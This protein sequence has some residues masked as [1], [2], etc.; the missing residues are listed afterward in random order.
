MSP[1]DDLPPGG[2]VRIHR[3]AISLA[4]LA[5]AAGAVSRDVWGQG[6]LA[7]CAQVQDDT[8][9]LACY[10]ALAGRTAGGAAPT[11]VAATEAAPTGSAASAALATTG[12]AVVANEPAAAVPAAHPAAAPDPVADFGLSADALKKRAPDD[13][14]ES[15]TATVTNVTMNSSNR[16]VVTLHTG[17][18]WSQSETDSWPV[19][20]P[21]DTV[22]I[23]RAAVGSFMLTGPRAV[24]WRVRRVR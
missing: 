23:K 12:V 8:R 20:K 4:I 22:T 17:Q 2:L 9:R 11:V 1:V 5:V 21:G 15:I 24:S 13:W 3:S 18:V 16:F 6:S 14:V 7:S 19:L 10:D